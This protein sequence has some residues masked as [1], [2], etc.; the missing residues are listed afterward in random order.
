MNWEELLVRHENKRDWDSAINTVLESLSLHPDD[1][2]AYIHAIYLFHYL[3]V[4]DDYSDDKQA[5]LEVLLRKSFYA[6]KEKFTDDVEYLFFVGQ[7]LYIAEWHFGLDNNDLAFE[8]QQKANSLQPDNL[9]YQWAVYH[10]SFETVMEAN[11]LASDITNKHPEIT[12]YLAKKGI[13]GLYVLGFIE[14]G[15]QEYAS[16]PP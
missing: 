15:S 10:Q 7:I 14:M 16:T 11:K 3:L 8:F 1:V 6:S 5:Y 12:E 4:E 9:L 2:W 13:P